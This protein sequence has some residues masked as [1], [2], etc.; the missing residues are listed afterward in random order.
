[1][2]LIPLTENLFLWDKQRYIPANNEAETHSVRDPVWTRPYPSKQPGFRDQVP[3]FD[4]EFT[5]RPDTHAFILVFSIVFN[6]Q[7]AQSFDIWSGFHCETVV[8][9][10]IVNLAWTWNLFRLLGKNWI[11][12]KKRLPRIHSMQALETMRNIPAG[13]PELL[14]L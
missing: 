14:F 11:R 9:T 3:E 1:M 8:R 4:I 12:K 7:L 5:T 13:G 10:L 6:Q 2:I